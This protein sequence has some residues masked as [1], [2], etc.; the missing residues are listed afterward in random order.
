[1][2]TMHGLEADVFPSNI[3]EHERVDLLIFESRAV[4]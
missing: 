3:V 1:M 4:M 2:G